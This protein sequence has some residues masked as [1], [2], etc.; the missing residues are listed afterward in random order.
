ML[1]RSSGGSGVSLL[2]LPI[3][4]SCPLV[5]IIVFSSVRVILHRQS[6]VDDSQRSYKKDTGPPEKLS[7][8]DSQRSYE[9]D[10]GPP[11]KLSA[12]EAREAEIALTL[13]LGT[14]RLHGALCVCVCVCM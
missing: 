9:K 12:D 6:S 8:D 4:P 10:T 14:E 7:A 2:S 11:E 1:N 5:S 13:C 3:C